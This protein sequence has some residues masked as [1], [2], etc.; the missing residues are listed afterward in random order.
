MEYYLKEYSIQEVFQLVDKNLIDLSP[1]YQRN[2]IWSPDNQKELID[3]I[4]KDYPLPSFFFYE[5]KDK[6]FEMVDGQ[7]RTKTIIR[8]IQGFITSSKEFDRVTFDRIDQEKFLNYRIS[9]IIIKTLQNESLLKEF[10]V[11]IN[12]KGVHLN[13]AEVNKSEFFDTNFMK[14]ANELLSYQNLINLDLFSEAVVKRMNDRSFVEELLAYLY[15]GTK[16]KRKS[17]EN[18]FKTDISDGDY[19]Y[20]DNQFKRVIDKIET[21]NRISP[22][23]ETRYKQKN[24]FYTLFSFIN[25]NIDSNMDLL[26]FQYAILLFIDGNDKE[27]R[28]MI[29]PSNSECEAFREYANNCI[30]QSNSRAARENRLKFFNALLKNEST[31]NNEILISVLDYL[32]SLYGNDKI[33]LKKINGYELLDVERI[34]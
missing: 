6:T 29:R 27:G 23:S 26:N 17:V 18:V 2:F 30:T 25:E 14:L 24:D 12:K 33:S 34:K 22:I 8:F 20:L 11:L 19:K 21:L 7:Q 15:S 28:Q 1:A 5:K 10:Y 3:T 32:S 16:E 13:I 9:V 4:L 31:Q